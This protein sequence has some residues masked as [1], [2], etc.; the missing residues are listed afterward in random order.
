MREA[1]QFPAQRNKGGETYRA[2]P[3]LSV[4]NRGNS[5]APISHLLEYEAAEVEEAMQ[6][7]IGEAPGFLRKNCAV[8]DSL[9]S[10]EC[11]GGEQDER[12]TGV[13][14]DHDFTEDG[15][16]RAIRNRQWHIE[17]EVLSSSWDEYLR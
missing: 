11:V 3:S 5:E 9:V 4:R 10:F 12:G 1:N 15:N 17:T 7:S 6:V 2:K 8:C 13:D 14:D 16:V